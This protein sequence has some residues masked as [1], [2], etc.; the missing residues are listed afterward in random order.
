[1][2]YDY[3]D[4]LSRA[5]ESCYFRSCV[6]HWWASFRCSASSLWD[7]QSQPKLPSFQPLQRLERQLCKV[8]QNAE[9]LPLGL[10]IQVVCRR[11]AQARSVARRIYLMV[12]YDLDHVACVTENFNFRFR[13]GHCFHPPFLECFHRLLARVAEISGI[14][15]CTRLQEYC[16]RGR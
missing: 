8:N 4:H 11:A 3:L 9:S 13:V 5:T 1:M 15:S 10:L 2:G 6:R 16:A 14:A 12:V 7:T